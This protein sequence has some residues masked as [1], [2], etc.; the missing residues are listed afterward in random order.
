[1]EN[2]KYIDD[3]TCREVWCETS[4]TLHGPSGSI[5]LEFCT[6]HWAVY[7]PIV[8]DRVTPVARLVMTAEQAAVLRDQLTAVLEG[9]RQQAE[10]AAAPP[11]SN[12]TN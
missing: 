5:K 7:P 12:L 10:L 3:L 6:N 11:A 2:P 8:V 1:M 9:A 4:Q